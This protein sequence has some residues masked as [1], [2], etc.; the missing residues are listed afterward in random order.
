[1]CVAFDWLHSN[2][3]WRGVS[4]MD[5]VVFTF[6][7]IKIQQ[8]KRYALFDHKLISN[9]RSVRQRLRIFMVMWCETVRHTNSVYFWPFRFRLIQCSV[10]RIVL[11]NILFN[12][13]SS[14]SFVVY[15]AMSAEVHFD[16]LLCSDF[17]CVESRNNK[18][19]CYPDAGSVTVLSN[20]EIDPRNRVEMN[21]E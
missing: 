13:Y 3:M 2:E 17:L 19:Y 5:G 20:S 14:F 12:S 15:C 4:A 18:R 8:I 16:S 9:N 21:F 11:A 10:S 6:C 1:M 7:E